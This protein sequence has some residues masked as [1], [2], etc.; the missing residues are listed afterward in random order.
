M[1]NP[2]PGR[3][4]DW[5]RRAQ[6]GGLLVL[7]PVCAEYLA[8]Y[9]DSTGRPTRLLLG[10]LLYVP[11]YGCSALLIRE[12]ARRAGL[13]WPGILL[14]ATAFGIFQAGVVD[15]SLFSVDYRGLD[16][17]SE[18][19]HATL[20]EPLGI[21]ASHALGFV[22][23]H[24]IFTVCA[25]V[26]LVEAVRPAGRLTPWLGRRWWVVAAVPYAAVSVLILVDHLKT[27]TSHASFD[28]VAAALLLVAILVA[29]AFTLPRRQ[30]SVTRAVPRVRTV[31]LL[32]LLTA[33]VQGMAPETWVGVAMTLGALVVAAAGIAYGARLVGWSHRHIAAIAAAPLLVRALLAF[34]YD[35]L[36]GDVDRAAKYAHNATMLVLVLGVTLVAVR[37][38]AR[39]RAEP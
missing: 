30:R 29:T 39:V 12:A 14:L 9:D 25:P 3:H 5:A 15:Q 21:S 24:V 6:V 10:L 7:A 34:L 36:F 20:I 17:W 19:F 28:Q 22:G 16:T 23:G 1:A 35:P 8:A 26:A 18:T 27:Q 37:Q 33:T 11:L 31:L 2:Q 4:G 13:G 38:R 32:A